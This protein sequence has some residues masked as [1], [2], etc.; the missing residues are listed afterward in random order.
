[1]AHHEIVV[2]DSI[3]IYRYEKGEKGY[4]FPKLLSSL[5]NHTTPRGESGLPVSVKVA[6][7]ELSIE[8]TP[9][10][11]FLLSAR[12]EGDTLELNLRTELKNPSGHKEV[13]HP[14]MFARRFVDYAMQFFKANDVSVNNFQGM[15]QSYSDNYAEF[16]KN[17]KTMSPLEA[18]RQTWTGRTMARHG[19]TPKDVLVTGSH[20]ELARHTVLVDFSRS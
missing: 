9:R 7:A 19:F 3:G 15:W 8:S 17:V 1:M 4:H 18:A 11:D 2:P 13:Y 10:P 20:R 6:R 5:A 12:V 16:M 14:D